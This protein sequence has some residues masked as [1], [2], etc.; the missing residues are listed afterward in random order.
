M[1]CSLEAAVDPVAEFLF[2]VAQISNGVAVPLNRN[3]TDM[4]INI[5]SETSQSVTVNG[6]FSLSEGVSIKSRPYLSDL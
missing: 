5:I 2:N 3:T 6:T 4:T 1:N